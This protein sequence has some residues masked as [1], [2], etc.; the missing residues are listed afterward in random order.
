MVTDTPG[1]VLGILTADCAPILLADPKA[2]IIGAAHAG[3]KGALKGIAES[4]VLAME[5]LGADR[6][7]IR[8]VIGPAIS[9]ANYEVGPD[10][11]DAFLTQ[12]NRHTRYFAP[13]IRADR[14]QFDLEAYVADR[15][16]RAGVGRVER[17]AACTYAREGEFFSFRRA[18]H[19]GEPD[20]GRHISAIL[21]C[22]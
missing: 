21:L 14:W 20:N 15:L 6:A 5:E 4:V 11:H 22:K 3:W 16:G 2:G 13:G 18:T 10:L 7:Q 9:Q 17:L 19:R 12:D 8:A 1:L